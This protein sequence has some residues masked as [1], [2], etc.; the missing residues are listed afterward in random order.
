[1][2]SA[3][4]YSRCLSKK[5]SLLLYVLSSIH[6]GTLSFRVDVPLT[7]GSHNVTV[8]IVDVFEQTASATVQFVIIGNHKICIAT[9]AVKSCA[10]VALATA[11]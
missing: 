1:M 7:I 8:S 9:N 3:V 4:M 11:E 2:C 6:T 10:Y 5:W